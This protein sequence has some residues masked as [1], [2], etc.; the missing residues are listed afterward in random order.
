M[1]WHTLAGDI[2]RHHVWP[3]FQST[4][5]VK[6][7]NLVVKQAAWTRCFTLGC[8]DSAKTSFVI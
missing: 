4:I 2:S 7:C 6:W 3:L 8:F 1:D 5:P